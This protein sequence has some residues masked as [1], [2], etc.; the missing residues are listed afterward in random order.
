VSVLP[1]QYLEDCHSSMYSYTYS[2]KCTTADKPNSPS[3]RMQYRVVSYKWKAQKVENMTRQTCINEN[4][5][6]FETSEVEYSTGDSRH[7]GGV[8][9]RRVYRKRVKRETY[10][11]PVYFL[12]DTPWEAL[13]CKSENGVASQWNRA[14]NSVSL[15]GSFYR[16]RG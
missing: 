9:N 14:R 8:A 13:I 7:T 16:G 4:L 5:S 10:N 11:M 2:H 15:R 1:A 12:S 6:L 3:A